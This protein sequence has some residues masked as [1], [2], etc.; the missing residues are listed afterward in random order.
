MREV[1]AQQG[2]TLNYGGIALMWR[3]GCIIRSAFLGKIKQAFDADA[4]LI[5]LLLDPFFKQAVETAQNGLAAGGRHGGAT[6]H[7]RTGDQRG[8]GL[9]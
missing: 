7:P 2:W 9:F 1:A 4:G 8:A 6:G 3:G 5:N